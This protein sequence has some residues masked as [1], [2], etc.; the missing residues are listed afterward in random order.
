MIIK[1]LVPGVSTTGERVRARI[2]FKSTFTRICIHDKIVSY[3]IVNILLT[4]LKT[5][6]PPSYSVV[7]SLFYS[8]LFWNNIQIIACRRRQ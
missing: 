7:A 3:W 6:T 1:E 5:I 2:H 8:F 4:K